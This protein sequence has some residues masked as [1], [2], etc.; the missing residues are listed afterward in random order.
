MQDLVSMDDF[1]EYD[2]P[3]YA[4]A[5]RAIVLYGVGAVGLL[6]AGLL[7][8]DGA[9]VAY[10]LLEGLAVGALVALLMLAS[11]RT[12]TRRT[13]RSRLAA[14][15]AADPTL[16]PG[17]PEGATHR[18]IGA[19]VLGK[20]SRLPGAL[21]V[22]PDGFVFRSHFLRQ[23][24][25]RR[26]LRRPRLSVPDIV[27]APAREVRLDLGLLKQTRVRRWLVGYDIPALLLSLNDTALALRVPKAFEVMSKL[28]KVLDDLRFGGSAA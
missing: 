21:Y 10:A 14:I 13:S 20:R 22:V 9:P 26:L 6:V 16:M 3:L 25:W 23:A 8:V 7:L 5:D 18:L 11:E 17:P 4:R 15:F 1:I 12:G 24:W 2:R 19:L 27:L 28:Q